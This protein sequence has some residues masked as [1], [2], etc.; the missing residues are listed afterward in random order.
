ML[1]TNG[2]GFPSSV[3]PGDIN[4]KRVKI[5]SLVGAFLAFALPGHSNSRSTILWTI[6]SVFLVDRAV[7]FSIC[8]KSLSTPNLPILHYVMF[9]HDSQRTGDRRLMHS[10]RVL[11]IL[12]RRSARKLNGF[13]TWGKRTTH[14][15][16]IQLFD[17]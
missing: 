11:L 14:H 15:Q 6:Y 10:S 3:V 17:I 2:R 7:A 1:S 13:Q 12:S 9:S 4:T 16:S 8:I 5:W